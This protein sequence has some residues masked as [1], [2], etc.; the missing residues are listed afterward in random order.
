MRVINIARRG[1]IPYER[2]IATAVELTLTRMSQV[3]GQ[4]AG[5]IAEELHETWPTLTAEEAIGA[6]CDAPVC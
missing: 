3:T 2:W 1:M 4:V 6:Y 5:A